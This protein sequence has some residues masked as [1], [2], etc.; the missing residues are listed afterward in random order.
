MNKLLAIILLISPFFECLC[1]ITWEKNSL[2]GANV[3]NRLA[4]KESESFQHS[5]S[6]ISG[7]FVPSMKQEH[8][9]L[10]RGGIPVLPYVFAT[11]ISTAGKLLRTTGDCG[12]V[13]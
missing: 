2:R 8:V 6:S 5:H 7:I 13:V 10:I 3:G 9:S 12:H 11:L 1:H 4:P